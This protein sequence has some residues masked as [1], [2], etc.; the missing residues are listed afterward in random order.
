L[1]KKTVPVYDLEGASV[2]K[3]E[4]PQFFDAPLR[5]DLIRRAVVAI[6]STTFQPQGRD[7]MAGMRTTA[8][9]IGVGH[10]MARV[11]RVKGERYSRSNL[12]ALAPM[13]VKWRLTWPPVTSKRVKKKI[14]RKELRQAMFSALAATTLNDVVRARGHRI[15]PDRELPIVVSDDVERMTKSSEALK[16]LKNLKIWEDIER[17]S[18]R[19]YRGGRGS[20]RGRPL[21]SSVS[22]LLVVDK[23]Q[24]AQLAFRNFTGVTV[25]DAKSLNVNDLAPGTHPGRLT[26]W[27]QSAL[28]SLDA[29]LGRP[30]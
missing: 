22:A 21:R 12:G 9:S 18:K 7:P 24:D 28:K 16:L 17:A 3:L 25:V 4:L 1:T 5:L 15:Q 11:P 20:T 13:T 10:A 14:N 23:K 26:I 8:E 19:H 29:R 6:Q 30:N 2:G 27:T